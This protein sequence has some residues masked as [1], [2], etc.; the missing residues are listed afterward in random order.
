MAPVVLAELHGENWLANYRDGHAF[1]AIVH[2]MLLEV[3]LL[4]ELSTTTAGPILAKYL[5]ICRLVVGSLLLNFLRY[6]FLLTFP[7]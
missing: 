2:T 6:L 7:S 1:N 4:G 3:P 5:D